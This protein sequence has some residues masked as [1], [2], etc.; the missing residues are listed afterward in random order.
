VPAQKCFS[1]KIR[2][3]ARTPFHASVTMLAVND[4]LMLVNGQAVRTSQIGER[5]LD[6]INREFEKPLNTA[7]PAAQSGEAPVQQTNG[8]EPPEI[9]CATCNSPGA[10]AKGSRCNECH[11]FSEWRN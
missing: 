8:A 1:V 2:T 6:A 7:E 9:S 5:I 10:L 11:T 4:E 3:G